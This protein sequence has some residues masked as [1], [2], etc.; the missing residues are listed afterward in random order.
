MKANGASATPVL[1]IEDNNIDFQ[2]I[3]TFLRSES[4]L[5]YELY[6]AKSL[7][8]GL[9]LLS[10]QPFQ[11]ILLDLVLPDSSGLET[12]VKLH[13][14]F[15]S[16]PIIAMTGLL[17]DIEKGLE[18]ISLGAMDYISK[19]ELQ[20]MVLPRILRYAIERKKNILGLEQAQRMGR[21][22]NWE[23]E[24][25]THSWSGARI[26]HELLGL[27]AGRTLQHLSDYLALAHESHSAELKQAFIGALQLGRDFQMDHQVVTPQGDVRFVSIQAQVQKDKSGVPIMIRGTLQDITDRKRI[28]D[29][30]REKELATK[31]AKIRRDFLAKT[32]HEIRT[33]LNPILL[34]TNMLL[35]SE[36]DEEQIKNI[37]T[38]KSAGQTL[39]ALVNDILDL[40]KIEAGKVEFT[41]E[42]FTL[43]DI[44]HDIANLMELN[45]SQRE[46]TLDMELDP[47]IPTLI[48]GDKVRLTQIL[49]NLINNAIKFTIKGGVSVNVTVNRIVEDEVIL[50]FEVKDTGIGIP[51][52]K[53]KVIFESFQQVDSP[54][55][56]RMGGTGL[57]LTI[58][59][60][61]V[62]LQQ[63]QVYVESI[64]GQGS[65]F[66]FEMPYGL[67]EAS[68][69]E[70]LD[71]N[72]AGKGAQVGQTD[73]YDLE[74]MRILL[75]ED[76]P[77][78]QLVTRKLLTKWN[79]EIDIANNGLEGVQ[80]LEKG[81]YHVVLMDLQMPVMDGLDATRY[82]RNQL[83]APLSDIPIIAM[84]AN[85]ISGS[86]DECFRVGMNDYT[87][88]PIDTI[89]FYGK[90][91]KYRNYQAKSA[92]GQ[93]ELEERKEKARE[94]E[95]P[96]LDASLRIDNHPMAHTNYTD[97][98]YLRDKLGLDNDI[99]KTTVQ[100]FLDNTPEMLEKMRSFMQE[101]SYVNLGR[102]VH[103]MKGSA[104]YM[105]IKELIEEME[106]VVR[107]TK[108][109]EGTDEIPYIEERPGFSELPTL[110]SRIDEVISYSLI[111]LEEK[112]KEI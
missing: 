1:V 18:A 107:I 53:L 2:L 22:G 29:L 17:P 63:G 99:V 105:G 40:S 62:M 55:N 11:A 8:E 102:M 43:A 87:S 69:V 109:M 44:F 27:K 93:L 104:E 37:K 4:H 6:H 46:L 56:R 39:L 68:G 42:P 12:V 57:G 19:D 26:I 14:A 5:T 41:R 84:T 50:R 15:P 30:E 111:E 103:K 32:S 78:N 100:K 16:H 59:K 65:T 95:E 64:E 75:V 20:R 92:Q 85:A 58:V 91:V 86:D 77:L 101:E 34:L 7:G 60:Q 25:A 112:L 81:D 67:F 89:N 31:E 83:S 88:K 38:I 73:E 54:I 49:L 70:E 96:D 66:W 97:L 36:L 80:M 79:A 47:Q 61:L 3:K 106:Q 23:L 94:R 74:G 48:V 28:S 71:D 35:E 98:S 76:E 13:Q 72:G 21:M 51:K 9:K 110:V 90:I 108:P 82:I 33:P 52:D 24:V 45:A 10:Q